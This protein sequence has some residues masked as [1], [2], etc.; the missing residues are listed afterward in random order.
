LDGRVSGIAV[1]VGAR[2]AAF[3]GPR[4]VL[5]S[6]TVKDLVA[7]SGVSFQDLGAKPL[8]GIPGAW[9]LFAVQSETIGVQQS[10]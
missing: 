5:V 8:R 3:A 10:S 9:R 6:A 4:E 7:G 2:I 1:H